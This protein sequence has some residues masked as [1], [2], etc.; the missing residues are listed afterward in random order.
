MW[1]ALDSLTQ[2]QDLSGNGRNGTGQGGITIGGNASSPILGESTST[3]FSGAGQYLSSAYKPFVNGSKRTFGF[4]VWR[5]GNGRDGLFGSSA[6]PHF[7]CEAGIGEAPGAGDLAVSLDWGT[8]DSIWNGALSGSGEWVFVV[9]TVDEAANTIEA[10]V[11]GVSLGAK[12]NA[13]AY[14]EGNTLRVGTWFVGA[15]V[16]LDGKMAHFFV[17]ESIPTPADIAELFKAA[18]EEKPLPPEA[19]VVNEPTPPDLDR[20]AMVLSTPD[21]G[22]KRWADD[23]PDVENIPIDLQ[24]SSSIPGGDADLSCAFLRDMVARHRDLRNR[25]RLVVQGPGAE[26]VWRGFLAK[27]PETKTQVSPA[28]VGD[29]GKLKGD[30]TLRMIPVDRDLSHW[31]GISAAREL[32]LLSALMNYGD[33][34]TGVDPTDGLAALIFDLTAPWGA[35]GKAIEAY[36][37][38]GA[39]LNVAQIFWERISKSNAP[40]SP[41]GTFEFFLSVCD[42]DKSTNLESSADQQT[43][44]EDT[45]AAGFYTPTTPRRWGRLRWRFPEVLA[46]TTSFKSFVRKLAVIGGEVPTVIDPATGTPGVL[47]PDV[48]RA[49]LNKT[50]G[51]ITYDADS[52]EADEFI[53]PHLAWLEAITSEQGILDLNRFF[54][55]LWGVYS[56]KLRWASPETFGDLWHVRR[57]EGADPQFNGPDSDQEFNG[58][59]VKYDDALTGVRGIVGPP[60]SGLVG[61]SGLSTATLLDDDPYLPLNEWGERKWAVVEAGLTSEAGAIRLGELFLAGLRARSTSG[62]IEIGAWQVYD[63]VGARYPAWAPKAG[64]RI[65]VDDEQNPVQR[66]LVEASYKHAGRTSSL[67]LDSPPDALEA[68]QERLQVVLVGVVD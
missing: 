27:T 63:D 17:V 47:G 8:T 6:S 59:I 50:G 45:D 22:G 14:T 21:G 46:G 36:Y 25:N 55:N 15:S 3:N 2:A 23:E 30:P 43:V 61:P 20:L 12:A 49:I 24:L 40:P 64:D 52:I 10:F 41:S 11:N 29:V 37:D 68:L 1:W 44:N 42:D 13:G 5:D 60:G 26:D 56:G 39:G 62:S 19:V 34:A 9:I 18:S 38:A 66:L 16:E 35:A 31:K 65:V 33:A 48:L 28:A 57:D 67:T 53:V 54:R 7:I 58:V 51:G 32:A 4:W